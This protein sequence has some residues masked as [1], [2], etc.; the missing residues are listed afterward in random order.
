MY[1]FIFQKK[2][3]VLKKIT[4]GDYYKTLLQDI[5]IGVHTVYIILPTSLHG[6]RKI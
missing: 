6:Y 3:Q 4:T 1:K 2:I 5:I